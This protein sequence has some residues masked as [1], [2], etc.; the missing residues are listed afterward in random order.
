M[1]KTPLISVIVP[2]YNV[3][4]YIRKCLE[5][6]LNQTYRNLE[7][8]LVDD[9]SPDD[10][11]KIC[12]DYVEKDPRIVVI[13]Q[14]N[15]GVSS[16]RNAGLRAA[17]GEWI[18][19]VDGDDWIDPDM[20]SYLLRLGVEYHSDIVQCGFYFDEGAISETMFC[21]D[22]ESLLPGNAQHFTL[23]DWERIGNST[24]NKLYRAECL[25][26]VLYDP[27]CLM[28]EDL[29]F[30][31]HAL[32]YASGLVLGTQAKYHYVQ[33][34]KSACHAPPN[35]ASIRSHRM[36]LKKQILELFDPHSAAYTYFRAERLR[37]DMHNCSRIVQFPEMELSPLK[38]EIRAD[39]R[40]ETSK[41]LVMPYL[42]VK[43]RFK[44]LLIA[45]C[46]PLYR[47]L[48]LQSKKTGK[49][50][51]S[52]H[53]TAPL[54]S[55]IIPVYCAQET[56]RECLDSVLSQ[57]LS[58][59]EVICVDDGSTDESLSILQEYA[60]RDGRIRVLTQRN[61]FAGTARN[62]GMENARGKYVAFL[63]ADDLYLPGSLE[64]M[65]HQA[66]KCRVDMLKTGFLYQDVT[67]G[68][69]YQNPYSKNSTVTPRQ[70]RRIFSFVQL[71]KRLLGVADV[72]WNG[73]YRRAF[74]MENA[75]RF[76]R[77]RCVND[78]SFFI[79]CL[80]KAKR[81]KVIDDSTVCYRVGQANSLIG[82]KAYYFENQI[83]SFRIVQRL[84][85]SVEPSLRKQIMAQELNNIFGWYIR[86]KGV[87]PDPDRLNLQ[88]EEFLQTLN[89][90]DIG[91]KYLDRFPYSS[92]YYRLRYGTDAPSAPN[93]LIRAIH[94][95]QDHGLAYTLKRLVARNENTEEP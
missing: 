55:V 40:R 86:L 46:W 41:I 27:A 45:W 53:K 38:D 80:L 25:R 39:L 78:H 74:L 24:C 88:M 16:A 73:L 2:V 31:L 1:M 57:S 28:G 3:A 20:Y 19:F 32:L 65:Y 36:L 23:N 95:W 11:G 22:E 70:R 63:D 90:A 33:H 62:L 68:K 34:D 82:K 9:G 51:L 92:D 6:I 42:S 83:E 72:P 15:G 54:V 13:H 81:I 48:L 60:E 18:G 35:P 14:E 30:N 76:N 64:T 17:T 87:S 12:D 84:C 77:L 85:E 26:D 44:L 79:H 58:A 69:K 50:E 37:M 10:S 5:S 67:T 61:Q 4:P 52:E 94:C 49:D 8:I 93:R 47:F 66:E 75:I 29:L 43:E 56:L 59:I 71:P 7:V 91:K 89:E 21:A